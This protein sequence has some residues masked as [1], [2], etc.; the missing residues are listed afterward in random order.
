MIFN[1]ISF[2]RAYFG[3]ERGQGLVEYALLVGLVAAALVTA[4]AA[5][6]LDDA[7]ESLF[8]GISDCVDFDTTTAC[9]V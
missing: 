7:I 6:L 8:G 4:T 2:I 5:G 3:S 9:N 1:A